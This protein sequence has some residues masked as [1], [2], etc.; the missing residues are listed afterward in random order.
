MKFV[1]DACM[2]VVLGDTQLSHNVMLHYSSVCHDDVINLGNG[3]LCGDDDRPSVTGVVFQT[4]PT[5]FEFSIQFF[6]ML[7][8]GTF[9][10]V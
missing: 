3:L 1:V 10:L 4:L 6:T 2:D 5:T 9:S 8:E 7:Y